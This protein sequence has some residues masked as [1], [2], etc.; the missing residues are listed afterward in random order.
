MADV[1]STR[2]TL[3]LAMSNVCC[4]ELGGPP[5]DHAV[6]NFY[7]LTPRTAVEVVAHHLRGLICEICSRRQVGLPTRA[8]RYSGLTACSQTISVPWSSRRLTEQP[9]DAR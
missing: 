3:W 4:C 1:R 5:K 6:A 9:R 8:R 7:A 2:R